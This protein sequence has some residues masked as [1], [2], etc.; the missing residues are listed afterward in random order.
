MQAGLL[1]QFALH[2]C[3]NAARRCHP[4]CTAVQLDADPA[5]ICRFVG[6]QLA[7]LL[8]EKRQA[9]LHDAHGQALGVRRFVR[10]RWRE[11]PLLSALHRG[12]TCGGLRAGPQAGNL[13]RHSPAPCH[14]SSN[15]SWLSRFSSSVQTEARSPVFPP[16]LSFCSPFEGRLRPM[17]GELS[18]RPGKH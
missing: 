12:N 3:F 15:G 6:I 10:R 18:G 8:P 9:S 13:C 16:F 11:V 4:P 2:S 5:R 1:K 7:G 17:E 14:L